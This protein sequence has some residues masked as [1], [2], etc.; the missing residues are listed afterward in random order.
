MNR[1]KNI[2]LNYTVYIVLI[3]L[4]IS[5]TIISPVFLSNANIR[6]FFNQIPSVGILTL[7]VTMILIA[8]VIDLSIASNLAFSGTVATWLAING[9]PPFIVIGAALL[10][11]ATWGLI[12]GF[13]ITT[14][15]LEPFI[16]TLGT[17]FMIRGLVLFFTN[18][19]NIGGV[20][21][22]FFNISNTRLAQT[23]FLSNFSSNVIVFFILIAGMSFV[24]NKT[25][26]GRYCYAVGSNREA[27]RLSGIKT[28]KHIVV[29][30]II[31]GLMAGIA[32]VLTMSNL[33]V[34]AP[35]EG[36]GLDLFALAGAI[37]G[38]S[39]FGGGVGKISGAIAGI[40]TIQVFQNGLSIM[41]VNTFMQ[42]VVLGVIVVVAI[43]VDYFRR[44][45]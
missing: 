29:V 17:S 22:W 7:A 44:E 2:I 32:G 3:I 25:R 40:L 9:Q 21:S 39:K 11:G 27:A 35:N 42:Q 19:V 38:G 26:F 15:K 14:F 43:V 37:I 24:L 30:Y 13:L 31:A 33:N 16:L 18:G 10:I 1:L 5:F 34:G 41:G 12:N 8:G 4:I 6:N 28:N 45:A 20:P 36:V 23:G